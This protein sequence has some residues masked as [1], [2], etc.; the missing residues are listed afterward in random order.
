VSTVRALIGDGGRLQAMRA[1]ARREYEERYTM[2]AN[3]NQLIG[4][5]DRAIATHERTALKH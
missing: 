4:I 5:Y 1:A 3:H 2:D